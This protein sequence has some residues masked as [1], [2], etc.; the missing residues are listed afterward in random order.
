MK[1]GDWLYENLSQETISLATCEDWRWQTRGKLQT[2]DFLLHLEL[3][4]PSLRANC[5][6]ANWNVIKANLSDIQAN[7]SDI[8]AK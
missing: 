1:N 2:A 8:W 4:F 3:P 7:W 6:Q 5:K